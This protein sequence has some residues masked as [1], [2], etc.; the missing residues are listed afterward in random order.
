MWTGKGCGIAR[1]HEYLN[2][3]VMGLEKEGPGDLFCGSLVLLRIYHE[4]GTRIHALKIWSI[5]LRRIDYRW[6]KL[7]T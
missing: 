7:E 6:K 3:W 2:F 4:E 5:A 1:G